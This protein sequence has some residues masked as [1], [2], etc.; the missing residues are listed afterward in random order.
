M[1][2]SRAG[3]TQRGRLE[4]HRMSERGRA[5]MV[6]LQGVESRVPRLHEVRA[7]IN[8]TH[9]STRTQRSNALSQLDGM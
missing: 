9:C 1:V 4:G 3:S 5:Q 7:R 2:G 6:D 8:H